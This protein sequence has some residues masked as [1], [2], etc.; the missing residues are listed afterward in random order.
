MNNKDVAMLAEGTSDSV[1]NGEIGNTPSVKKKFSR[2]KILLMLIAIASIA[3]ITTTLIIPQGAA[4]L[5]LEVNYTVGEKMVFDTT[6]T[7]SIEYYNSSL[8]NENLISPTTIV[9]NMTDTIEVIDFNGEY[10]TLNHTRSGNLTGIPISNSI[11]E[12][13]NKTGYST[14]LL[15]LG[16]TQQEIPASNGITSNSF[17]MQLLSKPEVK[18][19]DTIKVPYPNIDNS[20]TGYSPVDF[21]GD[22]I[23][24][25]KGVQDLTVPAGTYRVFRIDISCNNLQMNFHPQVGNFDFTPIDITNF[26]YQIYIEYG[27]MRQIKSSNQQTLTQNATTTIPGFSM[28]ANMDMILT[29]HIKPS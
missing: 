2:K 29:E 9:D 4:T 6:M 13:M 21:T 8:L 14:Y 17:L 25:F 11:I 23:M 28:T 27:T 26:N 1:T 3:V 20:T 5:P 12:K 24:T 7:A 16:T 15:D 22:L 19:G 10:Y 18:V